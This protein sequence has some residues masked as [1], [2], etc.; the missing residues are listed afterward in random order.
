MTLATSQPCCFRFVFLRFIC[1]LQFVVLGAA[2]I[3]I[4]F[5]A[6]FCFFPAEKVQRG[7]LQIGGTC[8]DARYV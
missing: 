4:L 3:F 2:Q 7:K 6:F 5:P 1:L 8:A